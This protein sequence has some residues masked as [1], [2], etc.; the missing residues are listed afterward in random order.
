MLKTT[1]YSNLVFNDIAGSSRYKSPCRPEMSNEHFH[2][3][4]AVPQSI[5]RHSFKLTLEVPVFSL[6]SSLSKQSMVLHSC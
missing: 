1:S 5:S 4:H 2:P 3:T 6:L